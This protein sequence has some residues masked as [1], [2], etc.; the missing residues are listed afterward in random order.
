MPDI[1]PVALGIKVPDAMQTLG[2]VLGAANAQQAYKTS[3]FDLEKKKATLQADIERN[4]AESS[5]A[6]TAADVARQTAPATVTTANEGAKQAQIATKKNQWMLENEQAKTGHEQ[7]GGLMAD[8]RV[9]AA[10]KARTPE[11]AEAASHGAVDA[12]ME[13]QQRMIDRGIDPKKAA[14]IASPFLTVAAHA[15]GEL[16]N[17][18]KPVVL[19]GQAA[20]SQS[21]TVAPPVALVGNGQQTIGVNPGT[22]PFDATGGAGGVTGPAI[23]QQLPPTTPAF[24]TATQT[25]GYVGPQPGTSPVPLVGPGMTPATTTPG[26]RIPAPVQQSRDGDALRILQDERARLAAE[27]PKT[28]EDASRKTAYLADM[29]REISAKSKTAVSDQFAQRRVQ[30]GP[31]VGTAANIEGTVA[32][33]NRDFGETQE[34]A[35]KASGNIANL[36][37]IK[38]YAKG[39][40][41]G[42]GADRRAL[43]N[44]IGDLLGIPSSEIGKTNTDLL[45]KHANMLALTGGNTDSARALAEAANP[46][47][48]MNEAAIR[49]AADYIIA[50]QKTA[51]EK[52]KFLQPFKAMNDPNQ[53][54]SALKEWNANADPRV[55]Q[56]LE[57]S[58]EEKKQMFGSMSANEYAEFKR[59]ALRLHEM[60]VG[61]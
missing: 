55:L 14:V 32:A 20:A 24:D 31:G 17:R 23:Q 57:M 5:S 33:N 1:T 9:I 53:Y 54:Q 60:G 51:I 46:N 61:K 12:V 7:I 39:A 18:L 52:Q 44:G 2:S 11:E 29:D 22:N 48:H 50:L 59:K 38:E 10:A 49:K 19:G 34:A 28:P 15:P 13:A 40:T 45:A 21:G 36:Q 58:P 3:Q 56:L 16:Y 26:A 42:T 37:K 35:G 6:V 4:A 27:T 8:P 25:P 47:I 43:A 30:S 41:V